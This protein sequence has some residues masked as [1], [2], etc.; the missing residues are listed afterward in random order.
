[1]FP[2]SSANHLFSEL[3]YNYA[4]VKLDDDVFPLFAHR[5]RTWSDAKAAET[6]S[7]IN[8]EDVH[9]TKEK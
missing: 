7:L 5:R 1:M 2:S 4:E 9:V 6:T 8:V 3:I